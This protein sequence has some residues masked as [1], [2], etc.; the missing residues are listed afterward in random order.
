MSIIGFLIEDI[1][2]AILWEPLEVVAVVVFFANLIS[3]WLPNK[4]SYKSIQWFLDAMNKLSMNILR[5]A[6]RHYPIN[7]YVRPR[8]KRA[9][10]EMGQT[11]PEGDRRYGGRDP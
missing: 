1:L 8:S 9:V 7:D 6:N 11:D 2:L 3:I 10:E 5:N 4:S